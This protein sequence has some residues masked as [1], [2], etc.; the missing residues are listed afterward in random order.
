MSSW[1]DELRLNVEVRVDSADLGETVK[2]A[3]IAAIEKKLEEVPT[4]VFAHLGV[5][6]NL[7]VFRTVR[8][9]GP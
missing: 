9:K 7:I 1:E 3:V 6:K 5:D 2:A 4:D 8:P